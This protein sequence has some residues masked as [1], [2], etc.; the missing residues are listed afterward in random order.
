MAKTTKSGK[1]RNPAEMT[2]RNNNARKKAD[3]LL[4][5]RLDKVEA[6]IKKLEKI[7]LDY[8]AAADGE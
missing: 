7:L 8:Q 5:A 1:P 3:V 6:L 2:P 4:D